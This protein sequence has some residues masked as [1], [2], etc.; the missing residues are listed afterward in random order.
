MS[1]KNSEAFEKTQEA[2]S[3]VI[4]ENPKATSEKKKIC[5]KKII[6]RI[7]I[8]TATLFAAMLVCFIG[9]ITIIFWGPSNTARDLLVM[10]VN[11]TS[12]VKP[13]ARIFLSRKQISDILSKNAVYS[14]TT[15]TDE[16]LI[17]IPDKETDPGFDKD[18]IQIINIT[19]AKFKAKL[20]IVNDPSRVY[21]GTL[22][23][24]GKDSKGMTLMDM[25]EKDKAIGGINAG[26]FVDTA[27]MGNG[28]EPLGIVIKQGEIVYGNDSGKYEMIGFDAKKKL[29]IGYMTGKEALDRGICEAMSF[30][31]IL[32]VNGTPVNITGTGGGLN[33]RT[34]IGQTAD[35]AVLLLVI[36]GRQTTSYGATYKDVI[37]IMLDYGAVNAANL[38]GG[39]STL[40]VYDGEILNSSASLYG[41]R[42]L[43]TAFLVRGVDNEE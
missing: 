13:L 25:I 4:Q 1:I 36:D 3:S 30:G 16:S 11:E 26:G 42:Q 12:A 27:G 39:S 20:M 2:E 14:P 24:Y 37:N 8:C 32:I 38:D 33:P 18:G 29:I 7:I 17:T 23:S 31:P 41:P 10:S 19:D 15:I 22:E 35:G 21:L 9:M 28:G 6:I 40:M 43:P 34:A 5:K